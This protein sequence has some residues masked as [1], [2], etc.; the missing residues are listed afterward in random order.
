MEGDDDVTLTIV[1]ELDAMYTA[2]GDGFEIE[3][4]G[5]VANV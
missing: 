3:I 5:F 2:A 4:G 1:A